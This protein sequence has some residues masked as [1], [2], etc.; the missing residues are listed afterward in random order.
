M[1]KTPAQKLAAA[2]AQTKPAKTTTQEPEPDPFAASIQAAM[3][4]RGILPQP[5]EEP[6]W[7]DRFIESREPKRVREA[8]ASTPAGYRTT[9]DP[10]PIPL[11]GQRVLDAATRGLSGA[12]APATRSVA[13]V[14][15][16]ALSGR[17]DHSG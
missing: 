3:T 12:S 13:G 6:E 17:M 16:G 8:E 14:I 2:L 4:R 1:A 11:N 5:T 15:A 9:G 7:H 10:N